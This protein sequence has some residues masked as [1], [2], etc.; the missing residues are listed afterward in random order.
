[1][2]H[3][4]LAALFAS[5]GWH[6]ISVEGNDVD[7]LC[8]AYEEAKTVKGKPT[9]VIANTTKGCGVSFM[10]N[11]A[12]WHHKVPDAEQYEKAAAELKEREEA[13]RNE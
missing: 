5:F 7:A 11:Q 4:D 12:G 9:A 2:H 3:H 1:M 6:V 10:E 13:A 8:S